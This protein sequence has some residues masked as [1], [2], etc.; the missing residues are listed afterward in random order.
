[1]TEA[2]IATLSRKGEIVNTKSGSERE[3]D[4]T[5]HWLPGFPIALFVNIF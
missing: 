3:D 1:L 5:Q 4:E 2:G